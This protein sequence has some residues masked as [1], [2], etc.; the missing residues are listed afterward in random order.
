[1]IC[2]LNLYFSNKS[3]NLTD[4]FVCIVHFFLIACAFRLAARRV[5]RDQQTHSPTTTH[6][7]CA[8]YAKKTKA[9]A[10]SNSFL[11][12]R[13]MTRRSRARV[14]ASAAR[15]GVCIR[16]RVRV[17]RRRRRWRCLLICLGSR[18]L[19]AVATGNQRACG[20]HTKHVHTAQT[21]THSIT[22]AIEVNVSVEAYASYIL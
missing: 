13:Q 5:Q 18:V 19:D 4:L 11:Y 12:G 6:A 8:T 14:F 21:L 2:L 22:H 16:V 10:H 17:R 9:P 1:M 3:T 7:M 15:F 20:A